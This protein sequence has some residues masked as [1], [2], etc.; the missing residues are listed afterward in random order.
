M[1][2]QQD[3]DVAVVGAGLAGLTAARAISEAG[4]SVAVLEARDRVG[5]R[6]LNQEIG[7]EKVVEMGG[8]WIGPTQDRMYALSKELGIETFPTYDVGDELALIDRKRYR[9]HGQMPR[10]NPLVLADFIQLTLRLDR[11][12]R[13]VP[14]ERPWEA[15]RAHEW[16]GQT[17]ESWLRRAGKT[18]KARS[19]LAVYMSGILA[20]ECT[21]FSLL[22]GLF[23]VR[24]ATNFET[25][26]SIGGGAQQDRFI[27]GS[28]LI[29]NG[30]AERLGDA[31]NLRAPVHRVVQGK[32]SV[33]VEAEGVNLQAERVV[34]ALPP[35]LAARISYDPHL[36]GDRD[37]LMQRMPQ[38][39][40]T[41]FNMV[42]DV[43]FWRELGLKGFAVSPTM[44]VGAIL[45]NSPPDGSP[46]VL[47]GFAIGNHSRRLAREEPPGRRKVVL[48]CLTEYL[49]PKAGSPDAYY[50]L[51]W[52]AERWT[53]GCYGA[54]FSPGGWTQYGPILREPVGRI[55]WAGT[56]TSSIWNGYMEGAV[57]S[58]ERAANEVLI[59]RKVIPA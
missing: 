36:P 7:E 4:R 27:G 47:V 24:S 50:E 14:L 52:S 32:D 3:V 41:K 58:G 10:M 39:T 56:E 53:R 9:Y 54:H 2:K 6:I 40:V 1:S 59:G 45:D 31:I 25:M 57:R 19:I 11:L 8:Q 43:P 12:A 23:Y 51:D 37:Q 18:S 30:L 33:R 20:A 44:P 13:Q 21:D 22:H 16:D 15:P 42:Y 26:A 5:G 29:A 46:G 48:D 38:G 28:Q 49:G 34:I 55:H 17:F 35:T